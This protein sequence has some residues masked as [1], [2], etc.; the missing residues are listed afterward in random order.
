MA[1]LTP[2][3]QTCVLQNYER[4]HFS[5]SKPLYLLSF[6]IATLGNEFSERT[7]K[8]RG[9][10]VERAGTAAEAKAGRHRAPGTAPLSLF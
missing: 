3:F 9:K 4:I 7:W 8:E 10:N 2:G 1:P 6:F 5:C